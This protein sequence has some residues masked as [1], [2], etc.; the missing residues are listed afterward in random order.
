MQVAQV[1]TSALEPANV[2]FKP[3]HEEFLRKG[4]CLTQNSMQH[5]VYTSSA[6]QYDEFVIRV[7]EKCIIVTVPMPNSNI[8]YRTTLP[9]YFEA[10]EYI[11]MHLNDFMEKAGVETL[12]QTTLPDSKEYFDD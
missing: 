11:T 8:Q 2:G 9:N 12:A 5:L 4:W 3:I 6:N 1:A 7:E 10:C